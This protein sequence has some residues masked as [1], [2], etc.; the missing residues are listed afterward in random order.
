MR[1]QGASLLGRL[2]A[3]ILSSKN[4]LIAQA[5]KSCLREAASSFLQ[6]DATMF[7]PKP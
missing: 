7:N 2:R 5:V 3:N 4:D 1:K 6:K